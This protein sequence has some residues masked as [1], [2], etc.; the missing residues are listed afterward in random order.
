MLR[1]TAIFRVQ[2]EIIGRASEFLRKSGFFEI[3]PPITA[4]N[5]DPGLRGAH[6]ARVDLY[7]TPHC[8]T[9]S[10]N[11]QKFEAIKH[12]GRIFAISQVVRLEDPDKRTTG[13]HL[14]EFSIVEVEAAHLG[15]RGIMGIGEDLI[16]YIIN[17][18][19]YNC[20]KELRN[21]DRSLK[22][23]RKPFKRIPHAEVVRIL[24]AMGLKAED[25]EE[26]PFESEV[27]FSRM[28][29]SPVW[30]IDYP[31]G[32]RGFYDRLNPNDPAHLMDFDLILP[33]GYGEVMSGGEREFTREGITRQMQRTGLNP[34]EYEEFLRLYDNGA[35]LPSSGFGIGVER[36]TRYICGLEH[37]SEASMFPKLP[38]GE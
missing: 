37:I 21:L 14:S 11:L 12:L 3:L 19:S 27:E 29:D 30:I 13:R 2:S 23:A 4:R 22:T 5:T 25:G 34:A 35:M 28:Q 8:V 31:N 36:L 1:K 38:G 32:S 17:S 24:K 7:G 16:C 33:G 10:I 18:V 9:S 15:Y 26:I 20:S 6:V